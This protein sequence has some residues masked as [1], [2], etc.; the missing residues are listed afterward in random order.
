MTRSSR[1]LLPV[2]GV[3]GILNDAFGAEAQPPAVKRG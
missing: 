1:K 3:V 2:T